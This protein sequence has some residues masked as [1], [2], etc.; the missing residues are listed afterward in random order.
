MSIDDDMNIRRSNGNDEHFIVG[1]IDFKKFVTLESQNINHKIANL[2]MEDQY[3]QVNNLNKQQEQW[4]EII[5][6]K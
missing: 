2:D 4:K 3:S 1:F 5:V 6:Q